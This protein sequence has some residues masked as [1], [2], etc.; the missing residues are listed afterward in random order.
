MREFE[1]WKKRADSCDTVYRSIQVGFLSLCRQDLLICQ[2]DNQSAHTTYRIREEQIDS[3]R[4]EIAAIEYSLKDVATIANESDVDELASENEVKPKLEPNASFYGEIGAGGAGSSNARFN[5]E[6]FLGLEQKTMNG[7]KRYNPFNED[8][9]DAMM[10]KEEEMANA[11]A[12]LDER[13]NNLDD[14]PVYRGGRFAGHEDHEDGKMKDFF[15]V[16][17]R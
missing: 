11:A 16:A 5:A 1:L 12:L 6:N 3:L 14:M 13:W 10:D 9:K 7:F 4:A 8:D 2:T 17:S 15:E